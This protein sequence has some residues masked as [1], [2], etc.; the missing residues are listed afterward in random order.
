[1]DELFGNE[2]SGAE[3]D[4]FIAPND[5]DDESFFESGAEE[6]LDVK[7]VVSK[8]LSLSPKEMVLDFFLLSLEVF[9]HHLYL[10]DHLPL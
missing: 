7:F 9:H 10:I 6:E 2:G 1:L 8:G 3:A 4:W 5:D